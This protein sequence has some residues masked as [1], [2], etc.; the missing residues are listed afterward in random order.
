M[1]WLVRSLLFWAISMPLFY[2][3]G[4]PMLLD[5]LSKKA[6]GDGYTQCTAQLTKEGLSGKWDS[7]L[8]P[9]RGEKYCHCV[10]DGLILTKNDVF[11]LVRHQ[12]A[13]GLTAL[14]KGLVDRCNDAL[15]NE[16]SAPAPAAA[17]PAANEEPGLI[18]L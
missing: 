8:T 17:P 9:A 11:D 2:L 14:S 12:P 3:Y 4:L 7:P 18:H 16:L 5:M 6:Q 13:A 15:Q 1:R 10:S